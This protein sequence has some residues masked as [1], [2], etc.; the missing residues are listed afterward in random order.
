MTCAGIKYWRLPS[1]DML[2]KLT[3]EEHEG[4]RLKKEKAIQKRKAMEKELPYVHTY[5][6]MRLIILLCR[7]TYWS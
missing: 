4:K 6:F 3:V 1:E 5:T 2:V 7:C